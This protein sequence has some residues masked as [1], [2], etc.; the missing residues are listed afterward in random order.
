MMSKA[1]LVC[2]ALLVLTA[3]APAANAVMIVGEATFLVEYLGQD[4]ELDPPL[5]GPGSYVIRSL[6][7]DPTDPDGDP[8]PDSAFD[9][10]DFA[11][12]FAGHSWDETDVTVC[13]CFFTPEGDPLGVN[14]SFDDGAVSWL[15]SWNFTDG[16]FG[17]D[18]D[19]GVVFADA[20]SENGQVSG[21]GDFNFFLVP[22]VPEPGTLA[23]LGL[24]LAGLVWTRR[25]RAKFRVRAW[26]G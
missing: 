16:N 4:G 9:V 2:G 11:F 3:V 25:R 13:E 15:L 23:L 6:P 21:A 18:F 10:L 26:A 22:S 8:N 1:M 7:F 24:G 14:F 5:L 20:T 17:F 19:D 12:S